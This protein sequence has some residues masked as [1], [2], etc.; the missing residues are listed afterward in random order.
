M[1]K[2]MHRFQGA[3][4]WGQIPYLILFALIAI[5]LSVEPKLFSLTW[6]GITTNAAMTLVFVA[7]AET[8]VILIGGIDLSVAGILSFTNALAT[9]R[10]G[11]GD[12]PI[13]LWLLIIAAM[14]TIAGLFNG[15]VVH[16]MKVQPFIVT[17]ATWSIWDGLALFVL[18]TEGGTVPSA[19]VNAVKGSLMGLPKSLLI[20]MILALA[21]A[22]IRRTSLGLN[23][24]AIGSKESAAYLTGVNVGRTK[25]VVYALA[26]F[27][28]ALGGLYQTAYVASG[29]PTAGDTYILPAIAAVVIGGT[30]L[31]GGDGSVGRTIVGAFILLLIN[32]VLLFLGV[33]SYYTDLFQGALLIVAVGLYTIPRI[34]R[35]R[36][37]VTT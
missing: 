2:I 25:I 37:G 20:I 12:G 15:L 10:L 17:L 34:L 35:S 7:A 6:L 5:L 28:S 36:L 9:V 8:L 21:W 4:L 18:P 26:G 22:F 1:M 16:Y 23:I 27:L 29:S 14:G 3:T 24:L 33:S 31:A 19:Y 30:S 11:H 32:N 13:G